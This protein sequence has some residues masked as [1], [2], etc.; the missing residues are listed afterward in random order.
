VKIRDNMVGGVNRLKYFYHDVFDAT[1][2]PYLVAHSYLERKGEGPSGVPLLDL[3]Q[4]ILELYNNDI[5]KLLD[6]PYFRRGKQINECVKQLLTRVHKG[7]LWMDRP[8]P[9]NVYLIV[10]ITGIPMDGEK[11][12]QCLEDKT[13]AKAISNE[14][15]ANYGAETGNIGI[16]INDINDPM[17][18][19]AT[20]FLG[21]KLMRKC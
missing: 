16:R 6:I 14:I 12:K 20:K 17:T 13:K 4:W 10:E 18:R 11:T 8:V 3:A 9:I 19:F 1:N 2:F 21:C 15:K 5:M 7:I